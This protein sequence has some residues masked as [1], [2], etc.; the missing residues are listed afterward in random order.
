M[1]FFDDNGN[2]LSNGKLYT[3]AASTTTNKATFTTAVGDVEN[4]NPIILDAAG[5][6]TL[7][8][9]GAYRFDLFDA[10]DNLVDST[11]DITAFNTTGI[12]SNAFFQA[13]SG[14][15]SQTAFTLSQDL[16]TDEKGLNIFINDSGWS[17]IDPSDYTVEG[18]SLTFDTAPA[19]GT[20]NI[21]VY[22]PTQSFGAAA[23]AAAEAQASEAAALTAKNAAEAAAGLLNI[24]SATSVAIGTGLKTFTVS[25]DQGLS[26]GQFVLID[27]DAD[28]SNYMYGQI[29]SYAGTTLQVN[30]LSTGGSGTFADWTITLIGLQ[31]IQ[32]ATGSLSDIS[33]VDTD[34]PTLSDTAIFTDVSD[35][36]AT[37]KATLGNILDLASGGLTLLGSHT[38]SNSTS[39]D[40]GSGL[41][42]D[43]A[44]DG[45]YDVYRIDIVNLKPA[46]GSALY[47]R[48]ST[49]GGTSFDN[50][51][52][53]YAYVS[54]GG[55]VSSASA[56]AA[57]SSGDTEIW[58]S[59]NQN[60]N[61]GDGALHGSI[62]LFNPTGAV[63]SYDNMVYFD[64]VLKSGNAHYFNGTGVRLTNA[65]IDALRFFMS[66]GNISSGNIYL[67]GI[68]K[69]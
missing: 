6:A 31:G 28:G 26:A 50:G 14:T 62:Y 57:N 36:N 60:V 8:I 34:T 23:S 43:A 16:G 33:G 17:P 61:A 29:T 45:T 35:S 63:S 21:Y 59:G 22:S 27:S 39:V 2:P 55:S 1:Q 40:I 47:L 68:K 32:G 65:D 12:T 64:V 51:A 66:T 37:K 46:S 38:A 48:T 41:D 54:R 69:A 9:S 19:S 13:F 11:D 5:R 30:V 53:D 4:P 10:N 44:I 56:V 18:T 15:G 52:T 24:S 25:A 67:Y 42:L 7:F 49:D 58:I 20:D 3:Y